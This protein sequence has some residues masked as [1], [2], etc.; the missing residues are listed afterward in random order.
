MNAKHSNVGINMEILQKRQME[1]AKDRGEHVAVIKQKKEALEFERERIM[2]DLSKV[3][4][5]DLEAIR[6]NSASKLVASQIVG[7][8]LIPIKFEDRRHVPSQAMQMSEK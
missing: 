5:G 8:P 1:L 2:E 7:S 3:K 4:K 6:R